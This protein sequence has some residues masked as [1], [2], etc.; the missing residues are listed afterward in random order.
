MPW[1]DASGCVSRHDVRD[2]QISKY[3]NLRP[4]S[5]QR[6]LQERLDNG[7]VHDVTAPSIAV[8]EMKNPELPPVGAAPHHNDGS[9]H[10]GDL[11]RML[12]GDDQYAAVFFENVGVR[13]ASV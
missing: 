2:S 1:C 5:M 7:I 12:D 10:I 6:Y 3:Y 13:T 11:A 4:P 8:E 9:D